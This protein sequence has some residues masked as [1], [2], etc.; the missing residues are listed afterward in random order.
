MTGSSGRD[1]RVTPPGGRKTYSGAV[2]ADV[3]AVVKGPG[4]ATE[5]ARRIPARRVDMASDLSALP[6]VMVA[7]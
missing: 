6:A 5:I 2:R 1:D 4:G 7:T 3:F